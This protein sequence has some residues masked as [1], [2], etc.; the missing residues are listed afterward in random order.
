MSRQLSLR[1]LAVRNAVS[2]GLAEADPEVAGLVSGFH[3]DDNRRFDFIASNTFPSRAVME[4][5]GHGLGNK[6]SEGRGNSRYYRVA[7]QILELEALAAARCKQVYGV[8]FVDMQPHD[9]AGAN[10][11]V[12]MATLRNKS[13]MVGDHLSDDVIVGL[14]LSHGGHL[15]HGTAVNVSGKIYEKT[16]YYIDTETRRI[17]LDRLRDTVKKLRSDGKTDRRIMIVA[18]ASAYPYQMDYAAYRSIADES[19]AMI[20]A[21]ISHISDLVA[22]KVHPNPA[23]LVDVISS[24]THK[25]GGP[26]SAF[27]GCKN[28]H[29]DAMLKAV[30][31]GLQ[32]GPDND[33][34]AA[35]AVM[36]LEAQQSWFIELANR[37]VNNSKALAQA[38]VERGIS[39]VGRAG[40]YTETHLFLVNVKAHDLTGDQARDALDRSGMTINGNAIAG[41]K[42][43]QPSSGIRVGTKSLSRRGL[44]PEHMN[45]VADWITGVLRAP[46]DEAL[47]VRTA[48][49]IAEFLQDFP[50]YEPGS[51]PKV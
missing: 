22:A 39:V 15:S 5:Q 2:R 19:G 33:A 40:D 50:R 3:T 44:E 18:G 31:P 20:L 24:T 13:E 4:A 37:V 46:H 26:K 8:D 41:D 32:G 36:M 25:A 10:E 1:A 35:K 17:N 27:I 7:P 42:I 38:L 21:D 49:E 47:A 28:K 12:Y 48:I 16:L 45:Q 34:I 30:F 43:G 51:E 23:D 29:V 14:A 11:A 6:Y 9:G